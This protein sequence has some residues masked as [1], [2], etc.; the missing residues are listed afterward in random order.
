[1][2]ESTFEIRSAHDRLAIEIAE[3]TEEGTI[4]RCT[5]EKGAFRGTVDAN[6]YSVGPPSALFAAI[7]RE[8]RGWKGVKTWQDR[9]H[10]L[11][12]N[13][14]CNT[15]GLVTLNIEMRSDQ[16]PVLTTLA[17]SLFVESASLDRIARD[18]ADLFQED[19]SLEFLSSVARRN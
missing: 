9:D 7:A 3:L 12:L 11:T 8:W 18:A 16:P 14:H 15:T 2:T 4:F 19:K 1:V 5:L 10:A 6:T 17:S 13:A